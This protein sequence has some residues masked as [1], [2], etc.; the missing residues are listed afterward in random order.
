MKRYDYPDIGESVYRATLK[1]GLSLAVA[2]KQGFAKTYAVFAVRY[3]GMDLRFQTGG[4][5]LDTP[6]GIAHYLEHKMFDTAEG[7][8]LQELALNGA[9]PNAFTANGMTAYY[10]E[11]TEKFEENLRILLSFVSVPYF[12]E[13]SVEKERGI[14]A[15]EIRMVED[16]PEWRV[17]EQLLQSLY[18]NHPIR[19]PIAGTV[20][21]ISHITADTLYDCHRMFYTPANMFLAVV[22]DVEPERI[23]A[24]AEEILPQESAPAAARDYG[25]AEPETV[26]ARECER[27]MEVSQP[28]FLVGFKCAV[29]PEGGEELRNS[30][31]GELACDILL[32]DSSPLFNRLYNEGLI[33]GGFGGGYDVLS[34]AAMLYAGGDSRDPH[35]VRDAILAEA[36]RVA[37][38]G[39]DSAR[40]QKILRG[41]YGETLRGFNSFEN[42]AM[43]LTEGAFRGYDAYRFAELYRSITEEDVRGF[44]RRN[45]TEGHCA[46]SVIRPAAGCAEEEEEE[47]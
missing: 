5:F 29:P 31:V 3:G 28:S 18:Q 27:E 43:L 2:P 40:F 22:G 34:G 24:I 26:A 19:V 39:V 7:N 32:G 17:Y 35:A 1:N 10:F 11:S 44:I 45:L 30:L 4:E 36:A 42:I 6:A 12:T 47:A 20:E 38:E 16:N 46:L 14:I 33:N 9:E 37:E 21:S 13:E 23:A 15:Q 41:N 8:A 25:A